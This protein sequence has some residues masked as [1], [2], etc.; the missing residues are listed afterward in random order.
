[1][2]RGYSPSK[3]IWHFGTQIILPLARPMPM[4]SLSNMCRQTTTCCGHN[5]RARFAR[6][7]ITELFEPLSETFENVTDPCEGVTIDPGSGQAAFFNTR[8]G[9]NFDASAVLGSGI[10]GATLG[11]TIA[12]TCL[13]DPTIASRVSNT[14]GLILTQTRSARCIGFQ[15]WCCVGWI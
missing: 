2:F 3:P 13:Q 9:I 5:T 11:S 6:P 15:R 10:D 8:R 1:M 7:N 4:L 12:T 14:G